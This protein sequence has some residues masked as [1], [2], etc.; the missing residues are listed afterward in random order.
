[1]YIFRILVSDIRQC[2]FL[3]K[4]HIFNYSSIIILLT[5]H[6]HLP[7]KLSQVDIV[8]S[9]EK[10]LV[11]SHDLPMILINNIIL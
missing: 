4:G 7:L 8:H 9:L 1:M 5:R 10:P 3:C 2:T 6:T 11:P